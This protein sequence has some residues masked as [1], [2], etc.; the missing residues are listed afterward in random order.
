MVALSQSDV[1]DIN[2]LSRYLSCSQVSS[3][4][5]CSAVDVVVFCGNAILPIADHVFSVLEARQDLTKVLVICGGIGHSTRFLY[6]AV[7]AHDQYCRLADEIDGLPEA[8]VYER[9][10]SGYYPK[11]HGR[12]KSGEM[13][14]IIEA[15]STNCGANAIETHRVLE[16]NSIPPPRSC[17]IVQEPTMSLRTLAAFQHTYQDVEPSPEFLACPTFIPLASLDENGMLRIT[18]DTSGIESSALWD[19]HRFID[20]LMGE[21]PRIRDDKNG[22]GPEGKDFIVHVDVPEEVEAAWARLSK[23]LHFKR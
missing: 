7:R 12:I 13:K 18:A 22:Y 19:S 15:N 6:E 11:L 4:Y 21:I 8:V 3:L 9:I 5:A 1:A 14:C 17:I 10:L 20:L 16:A 23:I 2:T